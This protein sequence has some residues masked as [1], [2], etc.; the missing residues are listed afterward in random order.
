MTDE[1][2]VKVKL[3]NGAVLPEYKTK[4]SSGLDLCCNESGVINAGLAK[5]IGTGLYVEIPKGYEAQVRTR[6]GVAIN[7][8]VIVLNSP[9]TIDSDYRGEIKLIL[10]NFGKEQ[11][12]YSYGDRLAQLVFNRVIRATLVVSDNLTDTERGYGGFGHTGI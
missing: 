9:G 2:V 4:G 10:M 5:L 11:F 8:N 12:L 3:D 6:S 1:I 7:S